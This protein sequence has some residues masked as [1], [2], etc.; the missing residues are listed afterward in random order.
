MQ[1]HLDENKFQSVKMSPRDKF[2][3]HL[4]AFASETVCVDKF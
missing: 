1:H 3:L 4:K 2:Y